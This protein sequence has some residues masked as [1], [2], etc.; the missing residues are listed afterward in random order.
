MAYFAI[1]DPVKLES[2]TAIA[3]LKEQGIETIMLT[4]DE[5][6]MLNIL[7]IC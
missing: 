2:K 5:E 1:T 3:S 4:G 7:L 6:K